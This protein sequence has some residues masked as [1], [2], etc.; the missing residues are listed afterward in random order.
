MSGATILFHVMHVCGGCACERACVCVCDVIFDLF[1]NT[2]IISSFDVFTTLIIRQVMT[3][4]WVV[5]VI[6][7]S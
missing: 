6:L 3:S 4:D 2:V 1:C 7:T 5:D